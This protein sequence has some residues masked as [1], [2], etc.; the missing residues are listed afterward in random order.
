MHEKSV[1][2]LLRYLSD[3]VIEMSLV[4]KG[5]TIQKIISV[6]KLWKNYLPPK[7]IPFEVTEDGIT[8]IREFRII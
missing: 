6:T 5:N 8:M 1:E 2:T 3:V 7:A 4:E